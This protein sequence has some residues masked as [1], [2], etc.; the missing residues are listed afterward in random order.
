MLEVKRAIEAAGI[1]VGLVSTG[2]SWTYDVAAT[3]PEVTEIEAGTYALMEVPYAYMSEFRFA[4]KVMGHVVERPDRRTAV[5]DVPIDAIG[6]P[7]GLPTVDGVPGVVVAGLDHHGVTLTSEG[8]MPLALG[9]GFFLLT[10]QQDI[11]VNRWDRLVG[12]RNGV[13]EA[14]F[15]ASARGCVH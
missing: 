2:E 9:D 1:Q 5:G 3:Y 13:V 8:D 4:A 6:A 14:V 10:H 7:N 12:V 11:T 15:E